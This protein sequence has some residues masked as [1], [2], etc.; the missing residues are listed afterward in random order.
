MLLAATVVC[1]AVYE[2]QILWELLWASGWMLVVLVCAGAAATELL[3]AFAFISKDP[4]SDS[5][6]QILWSKDTL[7]LSSADSWRVS[8]NPRSVG[9]R[10]TP[11]LPAS[12]DISSQ[13]HPTNA[14]V[15]AEAC[16]GRRQKLLVPHRNGEGPQQSTMLGPEKVWRG[17]AALR[18]SLRGKAH[19]E[20]GSIELFRMEKTP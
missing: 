5:V 9:A 7:P 3:V 6:H 17:D 4:V 13:H 20:R 12:P 2:L 1:T 10:E 8:D 18:A 16:T 19:E 15:C 11:A 14:S